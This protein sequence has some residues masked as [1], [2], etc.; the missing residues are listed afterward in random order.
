MVSPHPNDDVQMKKINTITLFHV[1]F[2]FLKFGIF[3]V[4]TLY[5]VYL[6]FQSVY[7]WRDNNRLKRNHEKINEGIKVQHEK[8]EK[9]IEIDNSTEHKTIKDRL[10]LLDVGSCYNPF[11]KFT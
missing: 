9:I 10:K 4:S 5:I 11:S 7:H 3:E 6:W 2:Q 1:F 8:D